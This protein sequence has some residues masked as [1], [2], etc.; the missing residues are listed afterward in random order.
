MASLKLYK[1]SHVL[2]ILIGLFKIAVVFIVF[3][4]ARNSND[5]IIYAILIFIYT[6]VQEN[7]AHSLLGQNNIISSLIEVVT[8]ARPSADFEKES[9]HQDLHGIIFYIFLNIMK[10]ICLYYFVIAVINILKA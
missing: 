3:A 2:T 6:E 7:R 4:T 1:N 10:L 8:K 9:M 5:I